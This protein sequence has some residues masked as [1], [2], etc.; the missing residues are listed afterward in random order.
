MSGA[1]LLASRNI[2]G[3][4]NILKK[5]EEGEVQQNDRNSLEKIIKS[6]EDGSCDNLAETVLTFDG[7]NGETD[8]YKAKVLVEIKKNLHMQGIQQ[9]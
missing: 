6:V 1:C 9:N 5:Y 8:K 7:Y 2:E 4:K 3:A